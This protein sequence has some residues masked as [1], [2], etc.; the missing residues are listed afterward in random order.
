MRCWSAAC[1]APFPATAPGRQWRSPGQA[2]CLPGSPAA[3]VSPDVNLPQVTGSTD[4]QG[5]QGKGGVVVRE[6]GDV[7]RASAVALLP[8]PILPNAAG[9]EGAERVTAATTPETGHTQA[10][11]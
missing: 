5:V 6:G 9:D 3:P 1:P 4:R 8:P 2:A 7:G 11:V 10:A